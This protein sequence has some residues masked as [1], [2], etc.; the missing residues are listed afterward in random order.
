MSTLGVSPV[1]IDGEGVGFCNG[2]WC[3]FWLIPAEALR[4]VNYISRSRRG[5]ERS[6]ASSTPRAVMLGLEVPHAPGVPE[7]YGPS[8]FGL[9]C[10]TQM[11]TTSKPF[12]A[13]LL[14]AP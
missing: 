10:G 11:D 9:L 12:V 4:R 13:K 3:G 1:V 14:K 5:L 6:C 7:N 2:D 8:Y